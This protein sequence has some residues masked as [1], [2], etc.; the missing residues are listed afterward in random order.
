MATAAFALSWERGP[1]VVAVLLVAS[2]TVG[3]ACGLVAT[4]LLRAAA[5]PGPVFGVIIGLPVLGL[6]V[7]TGVQ[8]A[9]AAR[10]P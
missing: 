10:R 9:R 5:F 3:V 8:T 2:G 1:Y 7:A 6:G 4:E